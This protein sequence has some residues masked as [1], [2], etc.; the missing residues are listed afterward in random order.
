MK[1]LVIQK[2]GDQIG[3]TMCEKCEDLIEA[4]ERIVAWS[5]AYPPAVFHEPS[6]EENHR[7]HTLLKA[8]GMTLDAFSASMGRHCLK[9]IGDIAKGA[10]AACNADPGS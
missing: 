2:I 1:W 6:A 7:A 4:L 10:L 9:G 3:L 8:H 5:E